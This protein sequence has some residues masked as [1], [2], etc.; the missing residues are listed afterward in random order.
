MKILWFSNTPAAGEGFLKMDVL[1]AGWLSSLAKVLK[2][3]VNLSVA[4]YYVRFSEPFKYKG[5][6]Y[7]PI[8]KKNW[9][10][11]II[12]KSLLGDYIYREDLPVYLEIINKVQPDIIHIHGTENPFGCIIDEVGIPVVVSIQGNCTVY[13]HKYYSGIEESYA[14]VKGIKIQS[15]YTWVFNKSYNQRYRNSSVKITERE[16]GILKRCRHVIGRTDW[17]RRITRILAPG[18]IYYHNDEVLRESFYKNEWGKNERHKI[19]IHSTIGES[20]FKGFETI[21]QALNELNKIGN[22]AEWRVA[23]ITEQGLLNK[24]VKKKLKS[25]YPARG[26]VLLGNLNERELVTKMLEAD[27]YVMPSHIENSPNSLCE[28]MILGMPCITTHAG[29]SSSLLKDKGEGLVI[30]DGDPWSMAGAILELASDNAQSILY[31][32]KARDRALTRHNIDK[33]VNELLMIYDNVINS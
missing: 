8:C 14:S 29:G 7:F 27:I 13:N 6:S 17:D 4:F 16:K 2:D 18:S 15:P 20:I 5:V 1:R 22:E 9:K 33:I 11:D 19:I 31:G 10:L 26:L 12:K 25:S 3:K 21:C 32:R 24:V 23:G 28:A 30:Q